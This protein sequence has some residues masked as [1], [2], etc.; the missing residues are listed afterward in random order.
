MVYSPGS[1]SRTLEERES[2]WE[3]DPPRTLR[4]EGIMLGREPPRLPR[5]LGE[6][7]TAGHGTL[8]TMVGIVHP[9]IYARYTTLG[10]PVLLPPTHGY[11]ADHGAKSGTGARAHT[12]ITNIPEEAP[13]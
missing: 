8:S 4:R 5:T 6:R 11:T 3:E 13:P 1:L 2:C 10:T 7:D 9:G 12:L